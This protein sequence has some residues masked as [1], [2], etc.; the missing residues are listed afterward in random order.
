[1]CL[2]SHPSLFTKGIWS[3]GFA[4]VVLMRFANRRMFHCEYKA[5][6]LL[7]P[8]ETIDLLK[9]LSNKCKDGSYSTAIA[10]LAHMSKNFSSFW[11]YFL[12]MQPFEYA[13]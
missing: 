5:L 10:C 8:V 9:E 3:L 13:R 12:F 4:L 6:L 7:V 1:M 2:G 11:I